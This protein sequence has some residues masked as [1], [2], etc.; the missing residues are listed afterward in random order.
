MDDFAVNLKPCSLLVILGVLSLCHV[1]GIAD[2]CVMTLLE[3][4]NFWGGCVTD[5]GQMPFG[6]TLFECD[7]YG[8]TRGNQA[9]PLLISNQG[10]YVWCEQPFEFSIDGTELKVESRHGKIQTGQHGIQ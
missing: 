2:E 8:D 5:G 1:Q 7:L 3:G 4:E 10:R 6:K 9:Q